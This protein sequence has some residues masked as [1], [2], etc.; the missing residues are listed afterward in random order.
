M[1][2]VQGAWVPSLIISMPDS[3]AKRKK[4]IAEQFV[5]TDPP[6]MSIHPT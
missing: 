4:K 5:P 3:E 1:I 6:D 2:P